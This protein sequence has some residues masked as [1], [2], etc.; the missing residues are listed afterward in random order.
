M[1][2][3][4]NN[5]ESI[6]DFFRKSKESVVGIGLTLGVGIGVAF[7]AATDNIGLWLSMGAAFGL[8]IGAAIYAVIS[9]RFSAEETE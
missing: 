9:A 7:G 4:P 3:E 2:T 5:K 8:M 6:E 1:S